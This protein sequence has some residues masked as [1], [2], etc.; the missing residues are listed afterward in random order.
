MG[1][2]SSL[3]TSPSTGGGLRL[4][5]PKWTSPH[6]GH[7]SN[8]APTKLSPFPLKLELCIFPFIETALF[9]RSNVFSSVLQNSKSF[10]GSNGSTLL[11]LN[12]S[13]SLS[14]CAS[15]LRL[16]RKR[17]IDSLDQ[18]QKKGETVSLNTQTQSHQQKYRLYLLPTLYFAFILQVFGRRW[19]GR[20]PISLLSPLLTLS[21]NFHTS[22]LNKYKMQFGQIHFKISTKMINLL[23]LTTAF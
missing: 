23:S 18:K 19:S 13:P 22:K 7:F 12:L 16:D 5:S 3:P 8:L 20:Q 2:A 1:L 15:S 21:G 17:T 6:R 11:L 10:S 14:S 9:F 4:R